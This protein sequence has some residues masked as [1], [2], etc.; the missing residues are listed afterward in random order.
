MKLHKLE[1]TQKTLHRLPR[2]SCAVLRTT[3]RETRL[4]HQTLL[5]L[6]NHRYISSFMVRFA[7]D[8]FP[9]RLRS[10][11]VDLLHSLFLGLRFPR[12]VKHLAV[13]R[14][15]LRRGA[16]FVLNGWSNGNFD[17]NRL[18]SRAL[19]QRITEKRCQTV[20][21]TMPYLQQEK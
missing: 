15:V 8:Y 18:R 10:G 4:R 20:T 5:Y 17:G 1:R 16:C 14:V 2:T 12:C 6:V 3:H 21:R 9:G 13:S 11:I 19:C 7:N